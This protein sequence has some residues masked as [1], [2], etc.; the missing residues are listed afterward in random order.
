MLYFWV[1]HKLFIPSY[2]Q[3]LAHRLTREIN[4]RMCAILSRTKLHSSCN[5]NYTQETA[6]SENLNSMKPICDDCN[7]SQSRDAP[8]K[9]Q[10][11]QEMQLHSVNSS[12]FPFTLSLKN[13]THITEFL[14][15]RSIRSWLKAKVTIVIKISFFKKESVNSKLLLETFEKRRTSKNR[16]STVR[17]SFFFSRYYSSSATG[18]RH[19]RLQWLTLHSNRY[20]R[21][22]YMA[23][24]RVR[25]DFPGWKHPGSH[26]WPR[27]AKIY[28]S[29]AV[30]VTR[31]SLLP[32]RNR[33]RWPGMLLTR[34]SFQFW[35]RHLVS[36][37]E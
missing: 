7:V 36:I 15:L 13:M 6:F 23:R 28:V 35:T 18:N 33:F 30:F 32:L 2:N 4:I 17:C 25:S 11:I 19:G 26:P 24:K 10:E 9:L 21:S 16:K 20:D 5:C 29:P 8:N 1:A 14:I 31:V 37:V 22:S 27:H 34:F 12:R 3:T